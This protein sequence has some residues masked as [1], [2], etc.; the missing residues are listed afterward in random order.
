[1]VTHCAALVI[2]KHREQLALIEGEE[3]L[4][5]AVIGARL[6]TWHFDLSTRRL[7]CSNACL[8]L[9]G[10]AAGTAFSPARF[11]EVLHPADRDASDA[12]LRRALKDHVGYETELRVIWPDG[13]VRWLAVRGGAYPGS[14]GRTARMEGIVFDITGRKLDTERSRRLDRVHALLSASTRSLCVC[15]GQGCAGA[16]RLAIVMGRFRAPGSD[17]SCWRLAG[18]LS[19]RARRRAVCELRCDLAAD[20]HGTPGVLRRATEVRLVVNDVEHPGGNP[21]LAA[22]RQ[23][24]IRA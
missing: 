20:R 24:G 3:R 9:C 4:R 17:S 19:P 18:R 15:D 12:A 1:M 2:A 22:L 13:S 16:C 8:A 23:R 10:P 14:D 7:V 21:M 5:L 11:L 6:G